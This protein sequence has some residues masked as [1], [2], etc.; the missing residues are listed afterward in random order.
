M[1][2]VVAASPALTFDYAARSGA[3][4]AFRVVMENDQEC[5]PKYL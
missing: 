1:E 4:Y 5:R 2:M 3:E